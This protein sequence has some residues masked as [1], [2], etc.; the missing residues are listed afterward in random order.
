MTRTMVSL[1]PPKAAPLPELPWVR[2]W[3]L[4]RRGGEGH[5]E[6][7][8]QKTCV[9]LQSLLRVLRGWR[10]NPIQGWYFQ[11]E[12]EWPQDDGYQVGA[13]C[14]G[15]RVPTCYR[16]GSPG[17]ISRPLE[18]SDRHTALDTARSG[19]VDELMSLTN[20]NG[21]SI[22][23]QDWLARVQD[24]FPVL[25][26]HHVLLAALEV[27]VSRTNHTLLRNRA[28][29]TQF[30]GYVDLFIKCWSSFN[31]RPVERLDFHSFSSEASNAGIDLG[32]VAEQSFSQI[33]VDSR[34]DVTL[35][36]I[37]YWFATSKELDHC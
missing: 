18:V 2:Y 9:P 30:M 10:S 23:V 19:D 29:Y 11:S 27:Y 35:P 37:C 25:P 7:V 26:Y 31:L 15:R 6:H 28:E 14:R 3:G 36:E 22:S 5:V 12:V 21:E 17:R 1:S 4:S 24:L 33:D 8:A 32:S 34:G 20:T 16:N 13:S